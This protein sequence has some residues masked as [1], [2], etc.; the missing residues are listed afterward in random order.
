M[1]PGE[2][3]GVATTRPDF[4]LAEV[5]MK[6][7]REES[8]A[9]PKS[10]K[11]NRQDAVIKA[12]GEKPVTER[13]IL[14][15]VGD[16]RYTREILRRLMALEVV[17][18]IG[19]GGS[20][21]PYLYKFVR[22]PEE[23]LGMGMVDPAVDIRMQRIEKKILEELGEQDVFVTEKQIRAI[24]G[25]NTGTG[26]ALRRLVKD[27]RVERIGRGGAGNPFTYKIN[28]YAAEANI[29]VCESIAVD[30]SIP[31]TPIKVQEDSNELLSECNT[32][33]SSCNTSNADSDCDDDRSEPDF[34]V[35]ANSDASSTTDMLD[36]SACADSMSDDDDTT[37]HEG[38]YCMFDLA[39]DMRFDNTA[40]LG[41]SDLHT[42]TAGGVMTAGVTDEFIISFL[43]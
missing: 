34:E 12:I 26:K 13:H 18:R 1:D 38:D 30:I 19:K 14:E 35:N 43:V 17:Q 3:A 20:N 6:R 7:A 39:K 37:S 10:V 21:D 29:N 25:D 42:V 33:A 36:E 24:V 28:Q 9:P 22:T 8:T 15:H 16:N 4:E 2:L 23:A 32:L 31:S 40:A 5:G 41:A 27:A 11:E